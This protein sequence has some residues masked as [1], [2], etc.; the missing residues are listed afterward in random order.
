MAGVL[1][2]ECIKQGVAVQGIHADQ[3]KVEMLQKRL[4]A[5]GVKLDWPAIRVPR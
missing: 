3:T 5:E 4:V 2:D 1:A